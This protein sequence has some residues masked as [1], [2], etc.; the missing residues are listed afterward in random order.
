[1]LLPIFGFAAAIY[2]FLLRSV[3]ASI[4]FSI[5]GIIT[6]L[7]IIA[8]IGLMPEGRVFLFA[9]G[10]LLLLYTAVKDRVLTREYF[11][12]VPVLFFGMT[13]LLYW[14]LVQDA[15][16]FFWDEYSHWGFYFKEMSLEGRLYN[17]QSMMTHLNYP[18]AAPVWQYFITMFD[19][20]RES[21]AY[22][23]N[24][25]LIVG[26]LSVLFERVGRQHLHWI[27]LTV[28]M[29][30]LLLANF[31]HGLNKI[32]VDHLISVVFLGTVL[33]II[34]N[35]FEKK[36][37]W[38]LAFPLLTLVYIKSVGLYFA[39]AAVGL[40]YLSNI[41]H[42]NSESPMPWRQILAEPKRT[43]AAPLILLV[44]VL[45]AYGAWN[46]R[47][48]VA[49]VNQTKFSVSGIIK[50]LG[51]APVLDAPTQAEVKRRFWEV[52]FHQQISKSEVSEKYNE[53][54]YATMPQYTD[55]L[56]LSTFG[57]LLVALL[58]FLGA[59]IMHKSSRN[60]IAVYGGYLF[61]VTLV[62]LV[63]V[64]LSYFVAF[65]TGG[66][67]IP[68]YV[69]YV[70]TAVMP[71][72]A[73]ALV[74]FLPLFTRKYQL[75]HFLPVAAVVTLFYIAETP[76]FKTIFE[77]NEANPFSRSVEPAVSAIEAKLPFPYGKMAFTRPSFD[78]FFTLCGPP[79]APMTS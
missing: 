11:L 1:M 41:L 29:V 9:T 66:L 17:A 5:T 68:S 32:Y 12:S 56:R 61:L 33:Q 63:I 74:F 27:V 24:F 40:L 21:N 51:G 19:G 45:G 38:L 10:T 64:Y 49:G 6:I 55:R 52:F 23:A 46:V 58:L 75:K 57:I 53:F 71:L 42:L 65:G 31:G 14:I 20:F 48:D 35:R 79:S 43:M 69:R 59:F 15:R 26:S 30:V 78:I 47:L 76:N 39:V 50:S 62:Y 73:V 67:R 13:A 2:V 44:L 22:Y 25:L 70:N 72:V 7:S 16:F 77:P 3:S 8:M 60:T 4:F 54:S 37:V 18:P 28:A 34:T 36:T